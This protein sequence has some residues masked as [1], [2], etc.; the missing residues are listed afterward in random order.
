MWA[1]A[2]VLGIPLHTLCTAT[3]ITSSSL[4]DF[5]TGAEDWTSLLQLSVDVASAFDG[6][7][8]RNSQ[9]TSSKRRDELKLQ[10]SQTRSHLEKTRA[11]LELMEKELAQ[12]ES[13]T[14]SKGQDGVS[15]LQ[16]PGSFTF[17]QATGGMDIKSLP[18]LTDD[19]IEY[20]A[21]LTGAPNIPLPGV[22]LSHPPA[23]SLLESG[24]AMSTA[25]AAGQMADMD[26]DE[27]N[28][29]ANWQ[30]ISSPQYQASESYVMGQ[31]CKT[32]PGIMNLGGPAA[33]PN[34]LS[35]KVVLYAN[36]GFKG[37]KLRDAVASAFALEI[38]G[39]GPWNVAAGKIEWNLY[40]E[41]KACTVAVKLPEWGLDWLVYGGH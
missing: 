28:M 2:L 11:S 37:H 3:S 7:E 16:L 35:N 30:G 15:L 20:D 32:L 27:D 34:L 14:T 38:P 13:G 19:A 22:S 33:L 36:A 18:H 26:M 39:T 29:Y 1:R 41:G 40:H 12:I 21:A 24:S 23:T 5:G 9:D 10:I 6:E 4:T 17:A 8:K 25:A 31:G